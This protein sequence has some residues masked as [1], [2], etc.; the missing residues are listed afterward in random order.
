MYDGPAPVELRLNGDASGLRRA[1]RSYDPDTAEQAL[2]LLGDLG[3][4]EAVDALLEYLERPSTRDRHL[5]TDAITALGRTRERRA[6][7]ALLR[8]LAE[9]PPDDHG[10]QTKALYGALAAIGGPDA[11]RALLAELAGARTGGRAA[12]QIGTRLTGQ[13]TRPVLDALAELR[14][15]EAVLPLL[16]ALWDFVPWGALPALRTIAALGDPRT[17]SALLVVA[18]AEWAGAAERKAAVCAL[19]ALPP[20]AWPPPRPSPAE[21]QLGRA[22]R[23]PDQET[24]SVA[25]ELLSR[26]EEGRRQLWGVLYGD[27]LDPPSP[28]ASP[29][30]VQAVCARVRERPDLFEILPDDGTSWVIREEVPTLIGLV[31]EGPVPAVRRAAAGA[32]GAVAGAR[33][34]AVDALLAALGDAPVTEAAAKAVARLPEPP[35]ERLLSLLSNADANAPERRGA[36]LALG[37]AGCAEAAPVLLAVLD[38]PQGPAAVRA[39]AADALGALR[40][41][42]AAGRLAAVAGDAEEPGTLRA[43]AVRAL[44]LLGARD[45]LPVVLACTGAPGEAVRLRAV[46]A[47]GSFPGPEAAARLGALV[48]ADEDRDVTLA[49]LDALGRMGATAEPALAALTDRASGDVAH[50]LVAALAACPAPRAAFALEALIRPELPDVVQEAAAD[51]LAARRSPEAVTAM[52]AVLTRNEMY[53]TGH[54]AALR[55]L[56]ATGTDDALGAVRTY[57]RAAV[58]LTREIRRSLD[59]LAG[60]T[61]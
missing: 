55:G 12:D 36:A 26:T 13:P 42:A 54:D 25:V 44:G 57:C 52:A 16:A 4:P 50:R 59:A 56:V 14:P 8:V 40:H 5:R 20:G 58:Y 9:R 22:L 7:P 27:R 3:G 47:L 46:E 41:G 24:S 30:V 49:A 32:L 2:E 29:W 53:G 23:D 18:D 45:T 10:D 43:R 61:P 48:A 51:A 35:V 60:R 38:D 19:A 15:P 33:A 6:V 39:A 34:E 1:M 11:V 31:G 17:A 28:D 21:Y 37:L